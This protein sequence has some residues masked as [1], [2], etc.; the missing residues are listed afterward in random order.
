DLAV[1]WW[2]ASG[3]AWNRDGKSALFGAF[4]VPSAHKPQAST[5]EFEAGAACI[6]LTRVNFQ[7]LS[8]VQAGIE[9]AN[10]VL[11]AQD[12]QV[13]LALEKISR[14]RLCQRLEIEEAQEI[15]G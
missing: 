5:G 12:Q 11:L 3:L 13:P 4:V 15:R 2:V 6:T 1:G 8:E 9:N 7:V 14:A 10:T